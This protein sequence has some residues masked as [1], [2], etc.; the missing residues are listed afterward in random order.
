M[1]PISLIIAELAAGLNQRASETAEPARSPQAVST[2]N[3][4]GLISAARTLLAQAHTAGRQPR[5]CDL[6]VTDGKGIGLG[7]RSIVMMSF[8]DND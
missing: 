3:D 6:L 2:A 4:E 8:N 7:D 5:K 1:D